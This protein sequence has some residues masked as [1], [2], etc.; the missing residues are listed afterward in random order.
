MPT[1]PP[2]YC[3]AS[4]CGTL[5]QHGRCPKH[6]GHSQQKR[7]SDTA[8]YSNKEWRTLRRLKLAANPMCEIRTHCGELSIMR[9]VATEVDHIIPIRQRPDLR[10]VWANLQSSCHACHSAKT[11]S[12]QG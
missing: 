3:A 9:Q 5:V 11:R 6:S 1:A 8:A 7:I 4:G 10:L 12:E 2:R